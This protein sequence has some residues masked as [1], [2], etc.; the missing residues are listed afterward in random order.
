[1]LIIIIQYLFL[2]FILNY[3]VLNLGFCGRSGRRFFFIH[4]RCGGGC[5]TKLNLIKFNG[6]M[7]LIFFCIIIV[8]LMLY[9]NI[10][11]FSHVIYLD[12]NDININ[13]G[14]HQVKVIMP[15]KGQVLTNLKLFCAQGSAFV[16]VTRSKIGYDGISKYQL[17]YY[18]EIAKSQDNTIGQANN[19]ATIAA[20]AINNIFIKSPLETDITLTI[21]SQLIDLL[22]LNLALHLMMLYLIFMLIFIFSIKL[23]IDNKISL[24][25]IKKLP[26]GSFLFNLLNKVILVWSKSNTFWVY[27][28]SVSIFIF[29]GIAAF[30]LYACLYLLHQ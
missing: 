28:L 8:I 15:I 5:P 16:F 27:F 22:S 20:D 18:E 21:K 6:L 12:N 9:F 1:M 19:L 11:F 10:A 29:T 2:G 4:S 25:I 26:L 24:E 17:G 30:S 13:V 7:L 3:L 23:I 14:D